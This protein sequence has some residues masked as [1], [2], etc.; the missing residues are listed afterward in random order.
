MNDYMELREQVCKYAVKMYE[1][2]W[3][4][5]SAGNVSARVAHEQDRYVITPTTIPYD[6]LLPEQVVV[7]DGEGD[8]ILDLDYGPSF[9][10]P[11]HT[12]VYK[13]RPDVGAIF[14]T[15]GTYCT[16]LSVLRKPIPPLI[17]ELVVYV[18]DEVKV[19]DYGQSGSEELAQAAV[20]S[21]AQTAAILL[22]NHGNL[23]VG[24]NLKKAFNVSALVER[25]AQ[26]YVEVLKLGEFKLLPQDVIETEKG[27]YEIVRNM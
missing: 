21:L 5:G 7:I 25:A 27:M 3:V 20:K 11:M 13:A 8:P 2:G 19:A 14:H 1:Q 4:T 18:G 16:I 26:V 10:W 24:K 23:C 9:E 15:H 6:E 12:E 22:A 17:E